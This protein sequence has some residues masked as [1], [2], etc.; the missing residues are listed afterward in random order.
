MNEPVTAVLRNVDRAD[1]RN[2][3]GME[4]KNWEGLKAI[5]RDEFNYIAQ[6]YHLH[7]FLKI[8][9]KKPRDDDEDIRGYIRR[10]F[11][12][13]AKL[14]EDRKLNNHTRVA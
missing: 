14:Y 4:S 8:Y 2:D 5:G 12:I 1:D 10:Y 7:F 3:Q 13:S 9:K 6:Q 11:I